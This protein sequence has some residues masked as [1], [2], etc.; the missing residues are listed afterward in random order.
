MSPKKAQHF[1]CAAFFLSGIVAFVFVQ[2]GH[3][4]TQG[5]AGLFLGTGAEV[6][7]FFS[8][9]AI[10][11]PM[12]SVKLLASAEIAPALRKR[13]PGFLIEKR[14][15]SWYDKENIPAAKEKHKYEH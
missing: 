7:A 9:L 13:I 15:H 8:V 12:V 4:H 1:I 14:C 10:F 5:Q 11:P 3:C 2:P 6:Y